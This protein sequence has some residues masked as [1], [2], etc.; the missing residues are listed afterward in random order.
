MI[1]GCRAPSGSGMIGV[2][3]GSGTIGRS[4]PQTGFCL[5]ED[6]PALVDAFPQFFLFFRG[7]VE[8]VQAGLAAT[9][10]VF[11][12][13]GRT[14]NEQQMTGFIPAIGVG[15]G[16]L[17]AL[18]ATGND[19]FGD[20]LAQAIVEYKV[21]SFEFIFQPLLFYG[22]RIMDNSPFQV[23]YIFKAL[24]QEEGAGLFATD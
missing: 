19:L 11:G 17:A 4:G 8:G 13:A 7:Q 22:I 18:M 1:N 23:K 6:M 20:A 2:V 5:V 14:L 12:G 15:I 16:R 3:R 9:P 10:L 21:L 24:V